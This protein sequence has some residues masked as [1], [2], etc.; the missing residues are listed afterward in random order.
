MLFSGVAFHDV[1]VA[2]GDQLGDKWGAI[3]VPEPPEK[4]TTH[5]EGDQR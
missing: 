5:A 1:S 4:K 3:A 2:F